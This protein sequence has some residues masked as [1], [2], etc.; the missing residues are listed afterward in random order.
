LTK[1]DE[2]QFLTC[3]KHG[4]WG[5]KSARFRDWKGGD[6]LAIIVDKS[7]A[8]LCE[9]SGKPF[10]SRQKVWDNGLFPHRIPMRFTHTL[11]PADRPPILG[12]VRDALTQRWGPRYGWAILNQQVL[13]SPAAD[14]VVQA[15]T[16]RPNSLQEYRQKLEEHLE[17]ARVRRAQAARSTPRRGR[18]PTSSAPP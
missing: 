16:S 11:K 18:P 7:L 1:I 12:D 2:Y 13:E 10:E 9:V 17:D 3:L 5:S 8:A 15:I 14:L 4:L 6:R